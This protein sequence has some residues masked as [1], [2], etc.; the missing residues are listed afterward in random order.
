MT[1]E[2]KKIRNGLNLIYGMLKDLTWKRYGV[3][4]FLGNA[5][6]EVIDQ[7]W[8]DLYTIVVW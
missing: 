4:Q 3:T 6:K 2:T 8:K 1:L 5:H 7:V